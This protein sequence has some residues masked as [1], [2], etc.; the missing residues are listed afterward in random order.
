M[1][2]IVEADEMFELLYEITPEGFKSEVVDGAMWMVPNRDTHWDIIANVLSQLTDRF[3]KKSRIKHD[4][5]LGLPGYGNVFAPDLFKLTAD[6]EHDAQGHWRY[7]DVE[8]VLEVISRGTADNDYGK[9]KAA[10]AAGGI[11]V[12][13]IV[14]PYAGQCHVHTQPKNGEYRFR[15]ILDFGEPIDLTATALGLTITTDEF[16]RD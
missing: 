1:A 6:A 15:R 13:A 9:K 12:H 10:Y 14:D 2:H 4:V 8:F 5:R 11:P 7:Q 3:G 16:P